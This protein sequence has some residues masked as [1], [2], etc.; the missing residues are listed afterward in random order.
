[1]EMKKITENFSQDRNKLYGLK[2]TLNYF[3]QGKT[4]L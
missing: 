1:M 4:E 3:G 2:K